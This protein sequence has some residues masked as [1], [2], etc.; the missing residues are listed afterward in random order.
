M[1]YAMPRLEQIAEISLDPSNNRFNYKRHL[2]NET[3][4]CFAPIGRL[5]LLATAA[6]V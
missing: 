6:F 1:S 2:R 3:P 4:G 5:Y